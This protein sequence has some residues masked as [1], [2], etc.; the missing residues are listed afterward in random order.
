MEANGDHSHREILRLC[1]KYLRNIS[2]K[3]MR[4]RGYLYSLPEGYS[5]GNVHFLALKLLPRGSQSSFI[6]LQGKK[7][8]EKDIPQT[9]D[10]DSSGSNL[11]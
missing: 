1:V 5:G 7:R 6:W 9:I 3:K 11:L 8:K 2:L 4:G 10:A